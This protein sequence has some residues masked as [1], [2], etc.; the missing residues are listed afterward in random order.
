MAHV[1]PSMV[2]PVG[3][4]E[5]PASAAAAASAAAPLSP[6]FSVIAPDCSAVPTSSPLP[7]HA[8]KA[9]VAVSV[10]AVVAF[11]DAYGVVARERALAMV[12]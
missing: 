9:D 5:A 10:K 4:G 1:M 3:A 7:E 8:I 11:V 6:A 12:S 2:K